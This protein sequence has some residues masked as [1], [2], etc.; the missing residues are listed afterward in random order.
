MLAFH[1]ISFNLET[2]YG[3]ARRNQ[4]AAVQNQHKY[5]LN[6]MGEEALVTK[7]YVFYF[8][9]FMIKDCRKIL[10]IMK[11]K[12]KDR[13]WKGLYYFENVEV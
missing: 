5:F 9:Y 8:Y 3:F 4:A 6:P 7:H 2:G 12:E 1:S 10:G 13:I 11:L